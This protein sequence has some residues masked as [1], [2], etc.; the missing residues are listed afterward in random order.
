VRLTVAADSFAHSYGW[1]PCTGSGALCGLEVAVTNIAGE[2]GVL[3]A[4]GAGLNVSSRA[5]A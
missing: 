4:C 5:P 3:E 1:Q 2:V